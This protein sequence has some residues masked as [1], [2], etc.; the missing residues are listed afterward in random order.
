VSRPYVGTY[1]TTAAVI[2][3]LVYGVLHKVSTG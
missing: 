3:T 1:G 2:N